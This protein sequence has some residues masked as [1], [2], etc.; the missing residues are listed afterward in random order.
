MIEKDRIVESF[1]IKNRGDWEEVMNKWNSYLESLGIYGTKDNPTEPGI[2]DADF[3]DRIDAPA[4][5]D[6]E[7]YVNVSRVQDLEKHLKK[8]FGSRN[9]KD[10]TCES[11]AGQTL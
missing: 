9:V 10:T 8:V 7:Y 1:I 4:G 5:V 6:L 2:F 3:S 11:E